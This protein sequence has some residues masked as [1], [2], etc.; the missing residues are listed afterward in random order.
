MAA[1]IQMP[2]M[3]VY[4][5]RLTGR[6]EAVSERRVRRHR[7]DKRGDTGRFLLPVQRRRRIYSACAACLQAPAG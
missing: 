1:D 6:I 2:V 3:P 5:S 7:H 4:S